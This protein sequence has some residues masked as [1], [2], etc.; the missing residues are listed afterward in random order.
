M[1]K[2]LI[3][4]MC[5]C[6]LLSG[7]KTL[8]SYAD[9][10]KDKKVTNKVKEDIIVDTK[11]YTI[12]LPGDWDGLYGYIINDLDS[13]TYEINF[14]EKESYNE[15]ELGFLFSI[16]LYLKESDYSYLSKYKYLGKL[17]VGKTTYKVIVLYPN[18]V[19]YT[20]ESASLYKRLSHDI[21]SIISTIKAKD[22]YEYIQEK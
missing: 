7:C 10:G 2:L 21:D 22:N 11:Y 17:K 14:Y 20:K 13:K 6:M 3:M 12:T 15:S 18:D 19:Q 16:K 5:A 8:D 1:K 9:E 4:I